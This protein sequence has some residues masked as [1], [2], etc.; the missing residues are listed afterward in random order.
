MAATKISNNPYRIEPAPRAP[1]DPLSGHVARNHSELAFRLAFLRDCERSGM[2]VA[3][4]IE[5]AISAW[6]TNR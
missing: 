2:S 4:E 5:S 1:S 6:E 3:A